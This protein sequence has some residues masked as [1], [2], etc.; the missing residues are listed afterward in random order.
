MNI[1]VFTIPHKNQRYPTVGDWMFTTN[2]SG[3]ETLVVYVS[4]MDN[5]KYEYLVA[6]HE[7]REAMICKSRGITAKQ[8]DDFDHQFEKEKSEGKHGDDDEPGDDPR[9]PYRREHF[10]ATNVEALTSAEL[11]VDWK[12]Y[13]DK[14]YS[15]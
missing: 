10:F 9:S 11:D 13:E 2:T 3:D 4:E 15:L 12:A 5:W 14:V 1:M 8:V 6:D 7:I